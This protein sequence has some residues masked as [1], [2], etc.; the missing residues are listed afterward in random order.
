MLRIKDRVLVGMLVI[1]GSIIFS[2]FAAFETNKPKAVPVS[3]IATAVA[4]EK[5]APAVPDKNPP[6]GMEELKKD[7]QA[8]KRGAKPTP[9][10]KIFAAAKFHP[11]GIRALQQVAYV[12]K[13]LSMW[14]NSTYGCCVS[15]EEAYN[16]DACGVLLDDKTVTD[17]AGQNGYLN[18]ADLLEVMQSMAKS[19]M[20]QGGHTYGVGANPVTVDFSNEATLQAALSIAPV[21]IGID[22][23]ALPQGAGNQ[24]GWY[25]LAKGT[26]RNEDHCV[27]L[28][29]F[30]S[31][32]YLF[33][34]LNVPLPAAL[35]PTQPGYL[36]F[37][38][39]TLGFVTHDWLMGTCSEAWLRN[40]TQTID[41]TAQPNPGPSATPPAIT[42]ALTAAGTVG[43]AFSYQI[44]A[45]NSPTSFA[46]TGM[47]NGFTVSATGLISGTPTSAAV[48]QISISATNGSGTGTATLVLTVSASPA[49]TPTPT[50]TPT[51]TITFN[52]SGDQIIAATRD[53]NGKFVATPAQTQ[54]AINQLGLQGMRMIHANMPVK[55][56][57]KMFQLL[58][59]DPAV[60]YQPAPLPKQEMSIADRMRRLEVD[61][62]EF[63][64][65]Q[66]K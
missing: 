40:P 66:T 32:S 10:H 6:K 48:S 53:P 19:G 38:W 49:P 51:A 13:K 47:P 64:K 28:G 37:T 45:S 18:G 27:G 7:A 22:A 8:F 52:L 56:V 61:F 15:S 26:Y 30:G 50:P 21:K 20:K 39:S 24:Q 1:F 57:I 59:T 36:L 5:A 14:G 23:N 46:A 62:M 9:A 2:Q 17:W 43:A 55:D 3:I 11:A 33:T 65:N 31:A 54:D 12:P 44:A 29:G 16:Q 35:T 4:Q 25:T 41:G 42:S 63:M 58:P 34:Q 60:P